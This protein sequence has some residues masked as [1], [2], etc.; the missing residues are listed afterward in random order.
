MAHNQ[1]SQVFVLANEFKEGDLN[2]GGTR[3]D[4]I[5]REA[6]DELAALS[7]GEIARAEFVEIRSLRLFIGLW[8]RNWPAMWPT[9]LSQSS[10]SF[11]SRPRGQVGSNVIE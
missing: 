8:I 5:R 4:R 2:V 10:S 7:L 9:L 11:S 3:D 1:L 6:R